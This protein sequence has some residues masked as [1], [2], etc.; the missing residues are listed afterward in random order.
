MVGIRFGETVRSY[1]KRDGTAASLIGI[2]LAIA[3]WLR[4]LL[5]LDDNGQPMQLAPDPMIP[6]LQERLKGIRLGENANIHEHLAGILSNERIFGS[7][8]Y[9]A[10]IGDRIEQIFAEEIAGPGAVRVTLHKYISE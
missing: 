3:G 2:P 10:G 8:L 6:E 4:Y 7:D 1:V 5:A 9:A